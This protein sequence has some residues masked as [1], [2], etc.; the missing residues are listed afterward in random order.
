MRR[1]FN[2]KYREVDLDLI[3]VPGYQRRE[4]DAWVTAIDRGWVPAA[5][6]V[7]TLAATENGRYN[8]VDGHQRFK[9]ARRRELLTVP[10]I[11]HY[12]MDYAMQAF[13]FRLMDHRHKLSPFDIHKA[14]R[15]GE[16]PEV[17]AID[18]ILEFCGCVIA[19]TS[20]NVVNDRVVVRA[21]SA[22]RSIYR[23]KERILGEWV[24]SGPER[25][26]STL[27]VLS[28]WLPDGPLFGDMIA[29][30]ASLLRRRDLD[31]DQL[32]ESLQRCTL[33]GMRVAVGRRRAH[34]RGG[35][36]GGGHDSGSWEL[37][38]EHVYEDGGL[39]RDL[40]SE[41]SGRVRSY[42]AAA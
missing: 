30:M 32:Q 20:E 17:L 27:T 34:E 35:P 23:Q 3:D 16:D 29:G 11:I 40:V 37:T 15:E 18:E 2:H 9:V 19:D 14:G 8:V 4:V 31:L 25:L 1:E 26:T 5:F 39:E 7:L 12:G 10:A 33:E 22:A 13:I 38:F 42:V 36:T 24:V 28:A 41:M 21:V 6:G